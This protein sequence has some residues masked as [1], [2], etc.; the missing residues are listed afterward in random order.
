M[1]Y[2]CINLERARSSIMPIILRHVP[3]GNKHTSTYPQEQH[4]DH[5]NAQDK[6]RVQATTRSLTCRYLVHFIIVF[7]LRW[8]RRYSAHLWLWS[9]LQLWLW[10][11]LPGGLRQTIV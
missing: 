1:A 7:G 5:T 11:V 2:H 10:Y 9:G 4:Y 6:H 3:P 8:R